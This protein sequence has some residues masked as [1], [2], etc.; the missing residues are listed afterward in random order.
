MK[1]MTSRE[2]I[3][4]M[5]EHKEADRVPIEDYP[6]AATIERWE[7]DGMPKG[8]DYRDYFGMDKI[9]QYT[10]DVSPQFPYTVIEETDEYIINTSSWGATCKNFKHSASTPEFLD[11]K[12]VTPEAW[13]EAKARMS[14]SPDR[15]N[16]KYIEKEYKKAIDEDHYKMAGFWFGFDVTHSWMV[17][18][19][20]LLIAMLEEPEWCSEMFNFGLDMCIGHFELLWEK[21]YKFDAIT[22]PDDMGFKHSQFFS[23]NTYRELLK[24]VHKRAIDWA[25]SKGIKSMM[26]SCGDITPFIPELVEIGLD[27]LNPLE[28]KAGMNPA[29]I[30]AEFGDK[31]VLKGGLNALKLN[32]PPEFFEEMEALVPIMKEN[33]GYIFSTDHSIP[34]SI[35]A[36]DFMRIVQRAKEL[37]KY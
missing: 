5:F 25:K 13:A 4:R 21:G 31:L 23:L 28:S 30:K 29:K 10:P 16:W 6:W 1:E 3:S 12:V 24:P 7:S 17:G 37:G 27:G 19:E 32:N 11:F 34:S 22:W 18:T 33:G 15:I 2:R 26:H 9:L 8:M 35:S 14:I 36:Q 20:T